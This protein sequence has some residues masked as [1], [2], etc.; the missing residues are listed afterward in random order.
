MEKRVHVD[1]EMS[2]LSLKSYNT[3]NFH[4]HKYQFACLRQSVYDALHSYV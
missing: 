4:R 3:E 1:L 2:L